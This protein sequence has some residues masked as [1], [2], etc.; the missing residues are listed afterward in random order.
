MEHAREA[1]QWSANKVRTDPLTFALSVYVAGYIPAWITSC[2][3]AYGSDT[4]LNM[5][6]TAFN[7]FYDA[8]IWPLKVAGF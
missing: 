7:A 2:I 3:L 6:G 8:A 5:M 1:L 4:D